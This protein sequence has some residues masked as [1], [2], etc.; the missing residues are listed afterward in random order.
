MEIAVVYARSPRLRLESNRNI[1]DGR[2]TTRLV[3]VTFV[4]PRHFFGA[5]GLAIMDGHALGGMATF[6]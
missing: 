5:K 3:C 1:V 6:P 4:L 2:L